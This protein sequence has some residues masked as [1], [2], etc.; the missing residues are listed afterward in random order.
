MS[1]NKFSKFVLADIDE[2]SDVED[3]TDAVADNFFD[4]SLTGNIREDVEIVKK[5]QGDVAPGGLLPI[6]LV[7][8][9]MISP[10]TLKNLLTI[11]MRE[12]ATSKMGSSGRLVYRTG[13]L[14]RSSFVEPQIVNV[15]NT[16]SLQFRYMFAPYEV[17]DPEADV[18]TDGGTMKS[19]LASSAR[20]PRRLFSESLKQAAEAVLYR[21]YTIKV[22]Q[23]GVS[24]R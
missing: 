15:D 12:I 13:R 19:R 7:N 20:S 9:R 10:F 14:I 6:R 1:L 22:S 24:Q 11:K 18:V 8:G 2:S 4:L 23:V 3:I 21:G 16:I 17:F 5:A